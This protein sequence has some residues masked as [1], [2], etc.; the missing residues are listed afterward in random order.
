MIEVMRRIGTVLTWLWLACSAGLL[1]LVMN[2]QADASYRQ[3]MSS[4]TAWG[5]N[6]AIQAHCAEQA[7]YP[8]LISM[9]KFILGHD[10]SA[11]ELRIIA[12]LPVL[13]L[14]IMIWAVIWIIEGAQRR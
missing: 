7:N 8:N 11:A 6:P 10:D 14:W 3:C 13:L 5:N 12:L 2:G 1:F 4:M 9:A